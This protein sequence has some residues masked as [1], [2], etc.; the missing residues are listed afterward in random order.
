MARINRRSNKVVV[1]NLLKRSQLNKQL[2]P[3]VNSL[4]LV[5]PIG[6]TK[7]VVRMQDQPISSNSSRMLPEER[8]KLHSPIREA[9]DDQAGLVEVQVEVA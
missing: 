7:L 1:V 3:A 9:I 6:E 8:P 5:N 4:A 2:V